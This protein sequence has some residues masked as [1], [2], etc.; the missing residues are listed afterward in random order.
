MFYVVVGLFQQ[1][2]YGNFGRQVLLEYGG[3]AA[4]AV[5]VVLLAV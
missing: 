2:L 1:Y 5:V 4:F 3:T